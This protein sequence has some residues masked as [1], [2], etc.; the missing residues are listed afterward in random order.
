MKRIVRV[1]RLLAFSCLAVS[2]IL[3]FKGGSFAQELTKV[4]LVHV[5]FSSNQAVAWVAREAGFFKKLGLEPEIIRIGGSSK[6]VQTM[7]AGEVGLAH[8]GASAVI[9]AAIAGAD[10]TIVANTVKVPL[11]R[12][13]ASPAIRS[14]A[15][16]KGKKVAV[17]RFGSSTDFLMRWALVNKWGL[18]PDK[19]VPLIQVGGIPEML[20]AA[21]AGSIDA[22]PLSTPD[23]LRIEKL[24][25]KELADFSTLGIDYMTGTLASTRKYISTHEDVL[26][27]F[28]KAFVQGIHI[29]RTDKEFTLKALE[30][31]MRL[32][33]REILEAMYARDILQGIE[34][35]PA[36]SLVGVQ[37]ILDEVAGKRSA[38]KGR[39][40]EQFV[41]ARFVKELQESGYIDGLY[42][43]PASK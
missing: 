35:V 28:M 23:D 32:N 15:E 20:A 10:V 8:V 16:L 3:A 37:T 24:G 13:M 9:E 14:V 25:W 11:F 18:T 39:K 4:R 38:A 40:P 31:F 33:D 26:R 17:T 19:D 7:V 42:R 30:K 43:G 34:K 21:K 27:R 6:V 41:D 1:L 2:L 12:L 5:A 22:A 29:M 36:P